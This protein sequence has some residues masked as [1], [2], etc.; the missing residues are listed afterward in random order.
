MR[1]SRRGFTV[2]ESLVA[3]VVLTVGV[4]ALVGSS[5]QTV[6]MIGQGRHATLAAMAAA[7]RIERLRHL[8]GSTRPSCTSP[9]W[10]SDSAGGG[11]VSERWEILDPSGVGRRLRLVVRSRTASGI[12]TD[13]ILT[14]VLC[15]PA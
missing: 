4:L 11:G 10:R 1:A 6:R 15:G 2:A 5:A 8:A 13:T 12:A 3:I 7:G 14:A 9:E